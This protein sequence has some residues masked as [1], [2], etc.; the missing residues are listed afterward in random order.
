MSVGR[1]YNEYPRLLG[2]VS[3]LFLNWD[4]GTSVGRR[5]ERLASD[6]HGERYSGT[7]TYDGMKRSSMYTRRAIS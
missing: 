2:K 4:I 1:R 7:C 3:D 5:K 6:I